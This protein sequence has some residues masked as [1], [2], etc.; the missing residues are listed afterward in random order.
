MKKKQRAKKRRNK[1]K[2]R[3]ERVRETIRDRCVHVFPRLQAREVISGSRIDG[4]TGSA[5]TTTDYRC[6]A[7]SD[8]RRQ[9]RREE[10]T[11]RLEE[12][13]ERRRR[14]KRSHDQALG[15]TGHVRLMAK[16]RYTMAYVSNH[17]KQ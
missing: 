7:R 17:I 10:A 12:G 5:H 8:R 2:T 16:R 1:T 6:V 15:C 14:G 11:S 13:G 9:P 3:F 4:R